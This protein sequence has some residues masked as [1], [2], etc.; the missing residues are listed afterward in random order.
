MTSRSSAM[1]TSAPG[2]YGEK[3]QKKAKK[4]WTTAA[5]IPTHIP[6]ATRKNTRIPAM[7]T[8]APTI[9]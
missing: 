9:R 1:M 7:T 3:I 8:T 5:M 6:N 2:Q 4:A